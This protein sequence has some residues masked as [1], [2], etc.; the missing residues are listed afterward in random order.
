VT[1]LCVSL[2]ALRLCEK[3]SHAKAQRRKGH[4]QLQSAIIDSFGDDAY[5]I[6]EP[7]FISPTASKL[8]LDNRPADFLNERAKELYEFA[9][10]L[11]NNSQ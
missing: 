4:T 3:Q 1:L 10:S 7:Q 6:L 2:R 8:I 9:V 11:T 5:E